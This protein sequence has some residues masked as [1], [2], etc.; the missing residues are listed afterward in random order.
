MTEPRTFT[1]RFNRGIAVTIWI[2]VI[3][4]GVLLLTSG[5]YTTPA[6]IAAVLI[7]LGLVA[8][9]AWLAMWR[10]RLSVLGDGV[11]VV[12]VTHR[13]WIPWSALIDVR[14]RFALVL[15]TPGKKF[16]VWAAPAPGRMSAMRLSRREEQGTKESHRSV[17]DL[18]GSDSGD[19]AF[20]VRDRWEQLRDSG[21]LEGGVAD[22]ARIKRIP[23]WAELTP[24]LLGVAVL[25]ALVPAL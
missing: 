4:M 5:M 9:I 3:G 21:Q 14:T 16:E 6:R 10:P 23:H 24:L 2:L 18:L 25:A 17:G 20:L 1:S 22:Q 12:N 19:A 15:F 11:E 13:V 8:Y 7:P